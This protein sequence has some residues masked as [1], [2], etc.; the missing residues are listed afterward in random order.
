MR[1]K[2]ADKNK[3]KDVPVAQVNDENYIVPANERGF[4]HVRLEQ[5]SFDSK[6]GR[7]LSK[8]FVQKFDKKF[9][10]TNGEDNLRRQGYTI[11]ILH[12]PQ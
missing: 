4:Y 7:R 5:P 6:T 11:E 9:F 2:T 10:E 8:P 1:V 3:T 12:R